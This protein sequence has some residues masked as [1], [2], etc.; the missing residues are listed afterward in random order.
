[1]ADIR[2]DP[3]SLREAAAKLSDAADRT[4]KLAED[5]AESAASAPPYDGQFGNQV[6]SMG[7]QA[8]AQMNA[9]AT[10]LTVLS[11]A[12][13]LKAD[14]FEAADLE[15]QGGLAGL[16]AQFRSWLDSL[17]LPLGAQST[18]PWAF[19]SPEFEWLF[20]DGGPEDEGEPWYTP[21]AIELSKAWNW[22]HQNVNVPMYESLETWSGIGENGNKI[23]LYYLGQIWF[24]YDKVVNQPI[25]DGVET[26]RG[27]LDNARTIVQ[28]SLARLWFGYDRAVNQRIYGVVEALPEDLGNLFVVQTPLSGP[29]G[30]IS[31]WLATLT[32]AD[33]SGNPISQVG[34]ELANLMGNRITTV[35]F[36]DLPAGVVP[37]RG[38]VVLPEYMAGMPG[39]SLGADS[40]GFLSHEFTHVLERELPGEAYWPDGG[41]SL[42]GVRP[43]GDSTN[44]MEV[45]SEIVGL[46]VEYDLLAQSDPTAP[47]LG[48]I[49]D[50]LAT[51]TSSDAGNAVRYL[52]STNQGVDVYRANYVHEQGISDH[53][54]PI[55]G[56]DHWLKEMDFSDTA[57]QHIKDI[58]AQGTAQYTDPA[59]IDP[60]TAQL[61]TPSSTPTTTPATTPTPTAAPTTTPTPTPTS[62]PTPT[63]SPTGTPT[64]TS[65]P[66]PTPTA[67][68]SSTPP[69]HPRPAVKP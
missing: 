65:S 6:Q 68:P 39:S 4:R 13:L 43:I 56:W 44:Y 19:L 1:V 34:T 29:G 59:T 50:E 38:Y 22:C 66:S 31:D 21:L 57:V 54:I 14:E 20:K 24:A 27:N 63:Q 37:W 7:S 23:A 47:R 35:T 60:Q 49:Q 45:V 52:V 5:A 40:L 33:S 51:Y 41:L 12:L 36:L 58:A 28:Y 61:V 53:R 25:Y 2:V 10:K 18:S 17:G 48:D 8:F 16:F 30:P 67:T 15:T 62:T 9:V 46:T 3:P 64:S 55:E 32:A 26:W 11:E 69:S 42:V